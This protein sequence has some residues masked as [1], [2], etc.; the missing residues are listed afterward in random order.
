MED[1]Y[2]QE[3]YFLGDLNFNLLN[4]SK[5]ILDTKYAKKY[6]GQRNILIPAICYILKN[7][8]GPTQE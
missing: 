7:V 4:N 2:N 8:L 6:L 5:Y 1:I 3:V